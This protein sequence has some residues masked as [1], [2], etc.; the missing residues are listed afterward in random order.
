MSIT[1]T[2]FN[3]ISSSGATFLCNVVAKIALFVFFSKPS[4]VA[5]AHVFGPRG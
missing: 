4:G 1:D 3:G 2:E 5:S